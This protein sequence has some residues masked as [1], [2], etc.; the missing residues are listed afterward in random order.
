MVV[1]TES[2]FFGVYNRLRCRAGVPS[3]S[4]AV[5]LGV[6]TVPTEAQVRRE[7]ERLFYR[8]SEIRTRGQLVNEVL[9]PGN[10][11]EILDSILML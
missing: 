11:F 9:K 2:L 10:I 6:S 8:T 3:E 4:L 7:A 1:C 5:S